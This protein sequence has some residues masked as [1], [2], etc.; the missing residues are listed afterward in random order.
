MQLFPKIKHWETYPSQDTLYKRF[1]FETAK[2]VKH[3]LEVSGKHARLDVLMNFYSG[4][5]TSTLK[6]VA[7]DVTL[8]PRTDRFDF[9]HMESENSFV[10]VV[11]VDEKLYSNKA[12]ACWEKSKCIIA[13]SVVLGS[14]EANDNKL[15]EMEMFFAHLFSSDIPFVPN[16]RKSYFIRRDTNFFFKLSLT[17]EHSRYVIHSN[18]LG[19]CDLTTEVVKRK[20]GGSK[21]Q[22]R[23]D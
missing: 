13:V 15:L 5:A 8:Y 10:N 11:E 9:K 19:A 1:Y 16:E 6:F 2:G 21:R 18:P 4:D 22:G 20:K 17:I 12:G 23:C 14:G 7:D 3:F